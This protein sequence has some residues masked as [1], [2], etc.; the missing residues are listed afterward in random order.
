MVPTLIENNANSHLLT[1]GQQPYAFCHLQLTNTI[2]INSV[3]KNT[4][5]GL[6]PHLGPT[7]AS[8]GCSFISYEKSLFGLVSPSLCEQQVSCCPCGHSAQLAGKPEIWCNVMRSSLCILILILACVTTTT[9]FK[10]FI[11]MFLSCVLKQYCV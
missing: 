1:H 9:V 4:H 8:R 3:Y 2:Y 7:S 5:P 10:C 11:K 6:F